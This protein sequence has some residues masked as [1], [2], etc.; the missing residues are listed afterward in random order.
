MIAFEK[1]STYAVKAQLKPINQ[2][3]LWAC[4]K[5]VTEDIRVTAFLQFN[6]IYFCVFQPECNMNV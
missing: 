2:S 6:F 4:Q 3:C 1:K 5:A